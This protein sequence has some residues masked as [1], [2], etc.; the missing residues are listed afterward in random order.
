MV[1]VSSRTSFFIYIQILT[2]VIDCPAGWI[3]MMRQ[4]PGARGNE[5]MVDDTGCSD[6][7][8]HQF[9]CP[10]DAPLPKCG[11]YTHNNGNCDHTCPSGMKEVGSTAAG[12]FR[13]KY[14]AAC[15]ET[16]TDNMA[17]YN[18]CDWAQWPACDSYTCAAG[19]S[20]LMMSPTGSG[21]TACDLL[22]DGGRL[23]GSLQ[24]RRLCCGETKNIAWEDCTTHSNLGDG[25]AN[26]DN[27]CRSGCPLDK[28]R[29]A[30]NTRYTPSWVSDGCKRGGTAT[31]CR[32]K[33]VSLQ[34][35]ESSLTA[36]YRDAL[37]DFLQDPVC[38][39]P[40]WWDLR[41]S[42][43]EVDDTDKTYYYKLV[44]LYDQFAHHRDSVHRSHV[45][46]LPYMF[47]KRLSKELSRYRV[48]DMVAA[49]VISGLGGA[50][51]PLGVLW[52]TVVP[53]V[54]LNLRWTSLWNFYAEEAD[55]RKMQFRPLVQHITCSLSSLNQRI[56][57]AKTWKCVC[58]Q[59]V[60]R[61]V[62]VSARSLQYPQS[63]AIQSINKV[64]LLTR[65]IEARWPGQ[66]RDYTVSFTD[67][68]SL[69][70]YSLPVCLISC[71]RNSWTL[72]IIAIYS[73]YQ[74]IDCGQMILCAIAVTD[75]LQIKTAWIRN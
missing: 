70:I 19:T 10:S 13:G 12:C 43:K 46:D 26:D 31:C 59:R 38:Y 8:I 55:M 4:D 73:I 64:P 65:N 34:K 52:D 67:G 30:M 11:W 48:Q 51:T 50:N 7:G 41:R 21:A 72:L 15:C 47:Q 24:Q 23:T 18:L 6:Y 58:T 25:P 61:S 54:F 74:Q 49:L 71:P 66:V 63:P 42:V 37:D 9:C 35:R 62:L 17:A 33:S 69:T 36:T 44:H 20:P 22:M 60:C 3:R 14:Q 28:V 5:F 1:K 16:S 68:S 29:L 40:T 57:K 45:R 53:R 32:S 56:G 75:S 39:E 2:N 27:F